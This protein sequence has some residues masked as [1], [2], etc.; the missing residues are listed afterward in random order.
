MLSYQSGIGKNDW[1]KYFYRNNDR[2]D[3]QIDLI[4][5]LI[6]FA[7]ALEWDDKSERLGWMHQ[8]EFVPC[9]CGMCHFCLDGLTNVFG[10]KEKKRR[11]V[12]FG[13][14]RVNTSGCINE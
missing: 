2:H 14:T 8:S 5:S 9:D 10:H 11:M 13:S 12:N 1:K 6:N 3:F 7:I 4:F